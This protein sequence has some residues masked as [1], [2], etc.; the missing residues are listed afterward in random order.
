MACYQRALTL[1]PDYAE[2]HNNLGIAFQEQGKL[3]DAVAYYRN[4][5]HLRPNYCQALSNLGNALLG[6]NKWPEALASY[7]QALCFQPDDANAYYNLG[8]AFRQASMLDEA[9]ANFRQAVRFQPNFAA[10]YNNLAVVFQ[11]QGKLEEALASFQRARALVPADTGAQSNYLLCLNYLPQADPDFVFAEHCQWA[12]LHEHSAFTSPPAKTPPSRG[13]PLRVG[14]VSPDLRWHILAWFLEPILR[15]HDPKHVQVIAYAE[16][17][18][19]DETTARLQSLC[20]GWRRT[21]GLTDAQVA[22]LVRADGIDILVDLAGHTAGNRLGVFARKP[23]PIQATYLGYPTTTGLTSIDYRLTDSIAD[24]PGEPMRHTEKLLRLPSGFCCYL[25]HPEAPAVTPLP[26]L[27]AGHTT[28][29]SMHSPAK[30]NETVIDLWCQIL[31]MVPSA[32]LLIIRHTLRGKTQEHFA[33]QFAARG[34]PEHRV[35]FRH[36][37]GPGQTHLHLYSEI[38]LSLDTFP[39]SGHGTACE[40]L[41]MGV[42]VLTLRGSVHAG[43]MVA[44]VL[45]Q[46]GLK[47]LIA[48]SLAQYLEKAVQWIAWAT[49]TSKRAAPLGSSV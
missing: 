42:P 4:A 2:A 35:E 19:P 21:C 23:A 9:E 38:D 31:H 25:P 8:C 36:A 11:D 49:G 43:R 34:I 27:S 26:A 16:V 12:Q 47:D 41:W 7:Q 44:S 37:A 28:F 39:W 30:L 15:H 22:D 3:D 1:K 14:Y 17:P 45:H 32:R 29:G 40:S 48:D 6:Q 24:P 33:R 18:V 13:F 46:L 20:H 10:A 5:L